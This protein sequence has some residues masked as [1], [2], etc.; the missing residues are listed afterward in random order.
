MISCHR[1]R[2]IAVIAG[3]LDLAAQP[4]IFQQASQP[5]SEL[6]LVQ[7]VSLQHHVGDGPTLGTTPR[8]SFLRDARLFRGDKPHRNRPVVKRD[9]PTPARFVCEHTSDELGASGASDWRA[10]TRQCLEP[11]CVLPRRPRRVY[12]PPSPV[13]PAGNVPQALIERPVLQM[14]SR[15]DSGTPGG[16]HEPLETNGSLCAGLGNPFGSDGPLGVLVAEYDVD[17]LDALKHL[18]AVVG[19][20]LEQNVVKLRTDLGNFPM[21]VRSSSRRSCH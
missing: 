19:R 6:K 2:L 13:A 10:L 21:S 14:P 1:G 18:D 9:V 4:R 12:F 8:R 15:H 5:R 7:V 3:G 16:I 20:I 17:D 11:R